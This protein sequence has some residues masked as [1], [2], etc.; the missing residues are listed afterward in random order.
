MIVTKALKVLDYN[1][2]NIFLLGNRVLV[3]NK[4][5]A[6]LKDGELKDFQKLMSRNRNIKFSNSWIDYMKRGVEVALENLNQESYYK[7]EDRGWTFYEHGNSYIVDVFLD[8]YDVEQFICF[9]IPKDEI[10]KRELL[11]YADEE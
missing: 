7:Y 4:E 11:R 2:S 9:E 10:D 6:E 1:G 5:V 8:N 3:E